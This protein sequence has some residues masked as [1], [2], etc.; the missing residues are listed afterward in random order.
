M[1]GPPGP[2]LHPRAGSPSRLC[3]LGRDPSLPSPQSP[4]CSTSVPGPVVW[5]LPQ[6]MLRT[7]RSGVG[8]RGWLCKNAL[9]LQNKALYLRSRHFP[10]P[11]RGEESLAPREPAA[12]ASR[13]AASTASGCAHACERVCLLPHQGQAHPKTPWHPGSPTV[14]GHGIQAS[15]PSPSPPRTLVDAGGLAVALPGSCHLLRGQSSGPKE[16]KSRVVLGDAKGRE[17][18]EKG[19]QGQGPVAI[20]SVSGFSSSVKWV[21]QCPSVCLTK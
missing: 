20:P 17:T 3:D 13:L 6:G 11:L 9:C 14:P 18:V 15:A 8:G 7:E 16:S 4:Q 1:A 21:E 12:G 10:R 2:G 5:R 19:V